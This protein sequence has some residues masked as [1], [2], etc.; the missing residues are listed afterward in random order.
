MTKVYN[1]DITHMNELSVTDCIEWTDFIGI[2]TSIDSNDL[3]YKI[4]QIL[5]SE[6]LK[7]KDLGDYLIKNNNNSF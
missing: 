5:K 7:I 1:Q 6:N 2:E 3:D 4:L